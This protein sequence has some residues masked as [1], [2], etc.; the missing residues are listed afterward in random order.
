MA[1]GLNGR[2]Q[3]TN[4]AM[5]IYLD[6]DQEG[7]DRQYEHRHFVT[8]ADELLAFQAAESK[9]VREQADGRF[10]VA[11]GPGEDEILD[12]YLAENNESPAPIVVFFHGGR[13]AMGSKN[14]NCEAA[15]MYTNKG[16]HFVSVNFSLLPDVTMDVLIGQCRN[17]AAW[18]WRNADTFGGDPARMFVHGKSSGAHVAG[19]MAVT[20]WTSYGEL[21]ADLFKGGLLVSGMY[22]L[23]PVRLT[24]RNAWLKMNEAAA[25]A[26]SPIRHIPANGCKLIVGV[27]ALETDEFR[28]QSREFAEAWSGASL[29]CQFAEMPDR[30]H[31]SIHEDMNVA[32]SQLTEPF[33]SWMAL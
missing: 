29:Q 12:I 11:Y 14:S 27:G 10:D 24:F 7:L 32:T 9:R 23:E 30:H 19:M 4:N 31:F 17:A 18:V 6:Y 5:K 28:R 8:N 15:E 16:V 21:P 26:N 3:I 22:D 20:D 2:R 33:L 1:P 25:L 13:W